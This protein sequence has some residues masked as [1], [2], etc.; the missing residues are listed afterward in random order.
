MELKIAHPNFRANSIKLLL[1]VSA[2]ALAGCGGGDGG[3]TK[4][5]SSS[6][7]ALVSSFNLVELSSANSRNDDGF[8]EIRQLSLSWENASSDNSKDITYT[9]CQ[10]DESK[11]NNCSALTV[12]EN[13]TTTT[14]ELSSLIDAVSHTYFVL[15]SDG[16]DTIASSEMSIDSN[17]LSEMIG[18]FKA[19]NTYENA[20]FGN[21]V[22]L[23]SDGNT[24]AV[25]SYFESSASTGIDGEDAYS[26]D[27]NYSKYSGAVYIFEYENGVWSQSA[28]IKAPNAEEQDRFGSSLSLSADGSRLAVGAPFEDS[29]ATGINGDETNND[30]NNTGAVYLYSNS[31]S[32]WS[33][34]A[35]IKASNTDTTVGNTY[36]G[37]SV[38][39][40]ADG[41]VLA[42]GSYGEA[43]GVAGIDGDETQSSTYSFS[44]AVYVFKQV[45]S[46]WQQDA[47]LKSAEIS[48]TD[49]F[50]YSVA[51]DEDGDT[52]VVGAKLEDSEA[53]GVNSDATDSTTSNY[54]S[55]AAYIFSYA[56]NTWVQSAYLKASN[57]E[58]NDQFGS[59]VTIDYSGTV[60]AV[61]AAAEDSSATGVN[62]D[63]TDNE[64]ASS[65]AVYVYALEN[66]S[67]S[68]TAYIKASNTEANDNF[69][70]G[71][72]LSG[73]GTTLAISANKEDSA[74]T[75]L[76]G[77][78]TETATDE[79]VD[80]VNY[81]SGAGAVYLF[82]LSNSVWSQTQYIKAS[83]TGENDQFGSSVAL[84]EDGSILAVGAQQEQSASTGINGV[85]TETEEDEDAG[86]EAVNYADKSGAVYLY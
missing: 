48:K 84:T 22:E 14:V 41:E 61:S 77:E 12:V 54:N 46:Q 64:A 11:D 51:L 67:W 7:S 71:V 28:Y 32:G 83:N 80:G 3:S 60:V 6:S 23:S 47:Y 38:S 34:E 76:N 26:S 79:G 19:S 25:A 37:W 66:S 5:T 18:Y 49:Q 20:V 82:E 13:E 73:D 50:G 58:K 56:D 21:A 31:D 68:Q 40:S 45:D 30:G 8:G 9:V 24:L 75:G 59:V 81:A 35:Y 70:Q 2:L 53:T 15:A 29:S 55:G 44:G 57:T 43:G 69:G 72:K 74:A 42:V 33:K 78:Q 1:F 86:T 63:E 39:L 52:L 17:T 27:D 62:G 85:Q 10:T 4:E 16:T 36:F 65:G